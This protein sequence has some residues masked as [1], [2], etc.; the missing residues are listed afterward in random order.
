MIEPCRNC[1]ARNR[2]PAD[3]LDGKARCGT[4]FRTILPLTGPH[5]VHSKEE[6]DEIVAASPIPVLVDFWAPWCGPCSVVEPE[7]ER[8][9]KIR[10]GGTV[11]LKV[12]TDEVP[13]VAD[14]Y[15]VRAVPTFIVFSSGLEKNR[16]SGAAPAQALIDLTT[17][18]A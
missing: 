12:N 13:E 9:A 16:V 4:C 1:G 18:A 15:G 10:A 6:F 7:V 14:R 5:E 2:I 8:V 17:T 11:V 3:R